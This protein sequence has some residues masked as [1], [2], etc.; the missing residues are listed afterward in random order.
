MAPTLLPSSQPST[1]PTSDPTLGPSSSPSTGP[2]S[3]PTSQPTEEPKTLLTLLNDEPKA[4]IAIVSDESQFVFR[5]NA[6]G[7]GKAKY[8]RGDEWTDSS[9]IKRAVTL[10]GVDFKQVSDMS[11]AWE[12]TFDA[13]EDGYY[14]LSLR[15]MMYSNGYTEPGEFGYAIISMNGNER[16]LAKI[17]GIEGKKMVSTGWR[18]Y[19]KKFKLLKGQN[20]LSCGGLFALKTTRS[21]VLTVV[22]DQIVLKMDAPKADRR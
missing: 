7:G 17:D 8:A 13:P 19:S 16:H 2:T 21:E 22:Y 11:G 18:T 5:D 12:T 14:T 9:G 6:F 10:G 15:F 1:G 3:G 20:K 4:P